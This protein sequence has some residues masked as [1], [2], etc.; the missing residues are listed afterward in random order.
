MI[1]T[2]LISWENH[3][4]LNSRDLTTNYQQCSQYTKEGMLGKDQIRIFSKIAVVES[5][6]ERYS[7]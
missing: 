5:A 4:I 2:K 7:S 6:I 3:Q 1:N